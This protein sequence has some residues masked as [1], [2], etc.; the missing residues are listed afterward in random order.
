MA[1]F[2]FGS[3]VIR[4][5]IGNLYLFVKAITISAIG[6][7]RHTVIL[8][9]RNSHCRNMAVYTRASEPKEMCGTYL[10]WYPFYNASPI[11]GVAASCSA[12]GCF[13]DCLCH[14]PCRYNT[15]P[16]TSMD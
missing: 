10:M 2:K 14:F 16:R 15:R 5:S 1:D 3:P 9:S 11:F 12:L 13:K 8:K 4:S 6:K 7:F